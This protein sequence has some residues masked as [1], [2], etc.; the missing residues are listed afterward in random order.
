MEQE[1]FRNEEREAPASLEDQTPRSQTPSFSAPPHEEKKRS[2]LKLKW[3]LIAVLAIIIIALLYMFRGAFIAATVNGTPISR[4]AVV[5]EMERQVGAQVLDSL[6]NQALIERKAAEAD[7]D[8]TVEDIK[9][10]IALIEENLST[11]NTT[12]DDALA[13]QGMTRA[14]LERDIRFRK[15]AEMLVEDRVAVSEEEVNIYLEQNKEFLPP[16]EDEAVLKEQA[17]NMLRQQK[18][19]TAFQE[20]LTAAK[21]EADISYW[22]EY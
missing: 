13:Q 15:L 3:I 5:Q 22:K 10:E 8:V 7:L 2:P 21:A 17:R 20:W 12:L 1:P 14:D 18:F 4:L 19:S 9:K 11:Q 6:I 16:E